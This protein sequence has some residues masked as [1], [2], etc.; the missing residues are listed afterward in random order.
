MEREHTAER[1]Q[2]IRRCPGYSVYDEI[3]D[4]VLRLM[5]RYI[6]THSPWRK[7]HTKIVKGKNIAR[8]RLSF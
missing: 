2:I 6:E 3:S 1:F 8:Y 5:F 4:S 7:E